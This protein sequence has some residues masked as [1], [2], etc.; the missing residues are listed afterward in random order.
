MVGN[1]TI[2]FTHVG[3][4]LR[5]CDPPFGACAAAVLELNISPDHRLALDR[6]LTAGL[7]LGTG[8]TLGR[9]ATGAA[10]GS[11]VVLMG[12]TEETICPC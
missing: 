8:A 2:L 6:V 9:L 12:L 11:A 10:E 4:I 5:A 7:A 1:T 3:M